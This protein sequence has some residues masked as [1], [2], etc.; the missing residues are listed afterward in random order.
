MRK[1]L[2]LDSAIVGVL[3]DRKPAGWPLR[4]LIS[5]H[6]HHPAGF[7]SLLDALARRMRRVVT[8]S[9]P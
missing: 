6:P 5:D 7:K 8:T 9:T 3:A 4:W 1:T 2:R